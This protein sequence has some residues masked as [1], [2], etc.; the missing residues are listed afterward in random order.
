MAL[1]P[2]CFL[3]L[4]ALEDSSWLPAAL[5][6]VLDF[7]STLPN[8]LAVG[9]NHGET[10]MFR[11]DWSWCVDIVLTPPRRTGIDEN[12][13]DLGPTTCEVAL[14]RRVPP[15]QCLLCRRSTRTSYGAR[16]WNK[17]S[18][19]GLHCRSGSSLKFPPIHRAAHTCGMLGRWTGGTG[20]PWLNDCQGAA[21]SDGVGLGET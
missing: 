17:C 13:L 12:P 14:A 20:A 1:S 3:W 15:W 6:R 11:F 9:S 2:P 16:L 4:Q 7:E 18:M 8:L 5:R 21:G 19:D 10:P